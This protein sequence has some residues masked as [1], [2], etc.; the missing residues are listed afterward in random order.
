MFDFVSI[1]EM[2]ID[3]T[4][5]E[6]KN[7][8]TPLFR[9]N[10]GGAAA[11][12][13]CVLAKLG[14]SC[15]FSGKVGND[16]FGESCKNA[17]QSVGVCTNYLMLSA[18]FPTTLAFVCLRSDGNR[19][20]SFYRN[21][22]TADVNLQIEELSPALY[23]TRFFH[24]GSVSLTEEPL[25]S[26]VLHAVKQAKKHGAII[27]YD[28]NLRLSLWRSAN[29]ARKTIIEALPAA[30]ILKLSEEEV[31]FLFGNLPE[32]EIARTLSKRYS[33]S[34]VLITKA[35]KGCYA[36]VNGKDYDAPA[37]HLQT[38]DTTGA[39]DSFLAGIL[40]LLLQMKK[41]ITSLS[42]EEV[43]KML[44]FANALGSLV[45]TKKGAIPAIPTLDE[46]DQCLQTGEKLFSTKFSCPSVFHS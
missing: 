27:T 21:S 17:L 3:F 11:N 26:T 13:A 29:E 14:L 2:L 46:I 28:P 6:A 44:D 5:D 35:E 15:A 45:T 38:I 39:G 18:D 10:P 33:L 23:Q 37:Y 31:V 4:P 12:V 43:E 16:A 25:K 9:Q 32:Q 8:G 42:D 1:G 22:L 41:S 7:S 34:M 36:Y 20:F 19:T 40:F 24:F 30:D